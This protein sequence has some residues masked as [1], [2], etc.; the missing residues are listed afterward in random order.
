MCVYSTAVMHSQNSESTKQWICN[1]NN[2]IIHTNVLFLC[3]DRM[4]IAVEAIAFVYDE[5]CAAYTLNWQWAWHFSALFWLKWQF[6]ALFVFMHIAFSQVVARKLQSSGACSKE[7]THL[8]FQRVSGK[9][10]VLFNSVGSM[11]VSGVLFDESSNS[12]QNSTQ[13]RFKLESNSTQTRLKNMF[14][15]PRF[16]DPWKTFKSVKE[17]PVK[18]S[19]F[20]SNGPISSVNS[21]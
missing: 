3:V 1:H 17:F 14:F 10:G 2:H 19:N 12:T 8:T 5:C 9:S 7:F 21:T 13:I 4:W 6:Y 15:G 20:Q 11:E 16:F 18:W